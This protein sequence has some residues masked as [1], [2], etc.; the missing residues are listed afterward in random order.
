ML[1]GVLGRP[2]EFPAPLDGGRGRD[3]DPH[4]VSG[5]HGVD[6]HRDVPEPRR[7]DNYSLEVVAGHELS[8]GV[9]SVAVSVGARLPRLLDEVARSFE[10]AG[11]DVAHGGD[12]DIVSAEEAPKVGRPPGADSNQSDANRLVRG[13]AEARERRERCPEPGGRCGV[14]KG[15]AV[16]EWEW[17]M[18]RGKRFDS[19]R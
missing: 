13:S 7:R 9:I 19:L 6:G 8:I 11:L 4:E 1:A 10:V 3:F 16:H 18:G 5:L 14:E 12:L 15:S 2:H 17:G